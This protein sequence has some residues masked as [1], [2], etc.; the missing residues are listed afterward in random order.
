M[1]MEGLKHVLK[2]GSKA[3]GRVQVSPGKSR[4]GQEMKPIYQYLDTNSED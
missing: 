1:Q 4:Q 3:P 2:H